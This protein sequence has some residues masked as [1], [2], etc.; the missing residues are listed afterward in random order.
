MKQTVFLYLHEPV[1]SSRINKIRLLM[2]NIQD[3]ENTLHDLRQSYK[4]QYTELS[5]LKA[6][7]TEVW[8]HEHIGD[9]IDD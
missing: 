1:D 6:E 3:Q 4:T 9:Y 7:T 8:W 2:E 5:K